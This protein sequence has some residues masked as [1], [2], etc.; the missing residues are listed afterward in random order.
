[1][2]PKLLAVII[3]KKHLGTF[4]DFG[5]LS[6]NGNKII[7][8]GGGGA[9]L[10][11]SSSKYKIL[12]K[13]ISVCKEKHQFEY[14]YKSVGY[15]YKMPSINAALGISQLDNL[16][17]LKEKKKKIYKFYFKLFNDING[18]QIFKEPAYSKSNYWL[19]TKI[20]DKRFKKNK[21]SIIK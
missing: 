15:N 13:F 10:T 14:L 6:F 8:T 5:I 9:I 21:N 17:K 19:N 16:K 11:S 4:G 7:T 3:K 20:K 2:L 1:M 12:S 18:V